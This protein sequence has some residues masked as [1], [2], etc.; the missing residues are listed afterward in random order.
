MNKNSLFAVLLRSPW[1]V[2]IVVGAGIFALA[3]MA[4]PAAYAPY[5]IFAALP[6]DEVK[7]EPESTTDD[8]SGR[9]RGRRSRFADVV[10]EEQPEPVD[11][12]SEGASE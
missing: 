4:L 10:A 9:A 6:L 11:E 12:P 1:W 2:S 5:A 8:G 3:R 7:T